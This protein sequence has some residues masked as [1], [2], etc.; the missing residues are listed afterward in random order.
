MKTGIVFAVAALQM[1]SAAGA[2][3]LFEARL[4]PYGSPFARQDGGNGI[5]LAVS[6]VCGPLSNNVS[7][8]NAGVHFSRIKTIIAFGVRL[9]GY[10]CHHGAAC[11]ADDCDLTQD[12]YTDG[13]RQDGGPIAPADYHSTPRGGWREVDRWDGLG[14]GHRG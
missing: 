11:G 8:V 1:L 9:R 2:T 5:H 14:G 7:D 6:P 10:W 4:P 3:R 13:G 12:S